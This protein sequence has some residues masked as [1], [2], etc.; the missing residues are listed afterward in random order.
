MVVVLGGDWQ[1]HSQV[2]SSVPHQ[3]PPMAS[4]KGH[5]RGAPVAL[6][7]HKKEQPQPMPMP[8]TTP[9]PGQLSW[10]TMGGTTTMHAQRQASHAQV[11]IQLGMSMHHCHGQG[12]LGATPNPSASKNACP[13]SI[14]QSTRAKPQGLAPNNNQPFSTTKMGWLVL[15]IVLWRH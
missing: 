2:P 9:S 13:Q 5:T 6:A 12:R 7:M 15:P 3:W 4:P 14:S 1:V 8:I 11:P 10:G